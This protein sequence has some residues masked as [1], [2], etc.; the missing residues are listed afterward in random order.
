MHLVS[1][2]VHQQ[3]IVYLKR[4]SNKTYKKIGF[5]LDNLRRERIKADYYDK[6]TLHATEL[7]K[8]TEWANDIKNLVAVIQKSLS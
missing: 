4:N 5:K 1:R 8:S 3:I 7:V 6:I 2:N